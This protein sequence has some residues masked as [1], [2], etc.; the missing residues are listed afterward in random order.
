MEKKATL[1]IQLRDEVSKGLSSIGNTLKSLATQTMVVVTAIV[2]VGAALY[3]CLKSWGEQRLAVIKLD[4]ALSNLQNVQKGASKRLQELADSLQRTTTFSDEAII[5]AEALLATYGLSE[6]AITKLIPKLLDMAA[7]TGTDLASAA[8][9]VGKAIT[10]EGIGSLTRLGIIVD[11]TKFKTDAL[12]AVVDALSRQ[13]DGMA[14]AIAGE[15]L[16]K[17]TQLKN[18]ID[19]LKEAIGSLIAGPTV[20]WL[21]DLK[22]CVFWLTEQRIAIGKIVNA[23]FYWG[24]VTSEIID[25][26]LDNLNT[27]GYYLL[28]LGESLYALFSGGFGEAI[29]T[30]KS[31]FTNFTTDVKA[32]WQELVADMYGAYND[33]VAANAALVADDAATNQKMVDNRIKART[34]LRLFETREQMLARAMRKKTF[35]EEIA[36]DE[37]KKQNLLATIDYIATMSTSKNATMAAIGK[38]SAIAMATIDTHKAAVRAL[39]ST[40]P[41]WNF[42]LMAAVIA[43]GMAQVAQISAVKLAQGG[44]VLPRAGGVPAVLGEAGRAEA[45]I[46]LESPEAGQ[47][48]GNEIHIHVGTLIADDRSLDELAERM[49]GK[50][51]EVLWKMR[52]N[53]ESQG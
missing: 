27:L 21:E 11:E 39:G 48:I 28:G 50:I 32:N 10:T 36:L 2:A 14:E 26:I 43:A 41:P 31:T 22:T 45:V 30:L 40:V 52:K 44:I 53:K 6:A 3:Q 1:L 18:A 42:I 51:D 15:P 16:G 5:S 29:E 35:E 9:M 47:M 12:G 19:E 4:T 25:F 49:K 46:P 38:T 34:S 8:Y 23:F 37:L 13:F 20:K 7:A 33:M 24:N 17:I